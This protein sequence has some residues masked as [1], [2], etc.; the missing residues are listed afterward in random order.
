MNGN[1]GI[2]VKPIGRKLALIFAVMLI[3]STLAA[4]GIVIGLGYGMVSDL[5]DSSL[6]N[7][8]STDAGLVNRELNSTFYYLN[9]IGDTLE[10]CEFD[11]NDA[12][13]EYLAGTM[14][15]YPL[16]PTGSYL[17][18][19]DGTFLYPADPSFAYD[20]REQ[21]YFLEAMAYKNS[22]F[23][24]YDVPYFDDATGM[25]CA[26][27]QRKVTLKDGRVGV[28]IAD[29]MMDPIRETLEA[30][31]LYD[32]GKAMMVTKDG[33]ILCYS[34]ETM[35]GTYLSEH[36]DDEFLA[37]IPEVLGQED[38]IVHTIT[39]GDKYYVCTSNING[40]D[41][42]VIIYVKTSEVLA[43]VKQIVVALAAFTVIAVALVVLIISRILSKLIKKPVSELTRNIESIAGGD[44][45]V[46]VEAN[47]NDEIA[48]MNSAMGD[49]VGSMRNT[50]RDI[51]SVSEQ[52]RTEAR[53]SRETA[54]SLEGA[55]KEQSNSMEQVRQNIASI[56]AAVGEVASSATKLATTIEEVNKGEHQ[57]EESM[58]SLVEKAGIGQK[59][60]ISVSE[61]M[62][63]VV[64][65]M[66]E[67]ADAVVNVDEAA[68]KINNIVDMIDAISSQTNLLSLNASIEAA[69]AGEAGRGF[70][71]VASEIG[72]LANNSSQATSQI[73]AIILDMSAKVKLLSEKSEAN[74]E[75]I[76]NSA[77]YVNSAAATF[78]EITAELSDASKTLNTIA[79]QMT[80][81][82]DVALNMAAISEEQSASAE[83]ISNA[84]E[85]VT[86]AAKD[87]ATS[88][89]TV[90]NAAKSVADAV[91]D[92]NDNLEKF[93]I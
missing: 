65:S 36:E 10:Q 84:V 58:S 64:N 13:M 91:E 39:A 82:N 28:F 21:P 45:T 86:V 56:T 46:Q 14:G 7:E 63:D 87:V 50:I 40:T 24:Y 90:S 22:W 89:D 83:E 33:M 34:D 17:V 23:Y 6:S 77:G 74:S 30:V 53:T 47:G 59:D 42:Q 67:M 20:A 51:K 61:G 31:N 93:T 62:G 79:G 48:L 12:L 81:V 73:S 3:V 38:G 72:E 26:T 55:A 4:E 66:K 11:G 80:T 68:K 18:L 5:I 69:R 88:S 57:I 8:V 29:L 41:W 16:I 52:L 37:A 85:L 25:L 75:L 54:D 9:G 44:F 19:D 35:G 78:R 71:V 70:A 27:V 49:F 15:R 2:T 32:T 43:A 76:N 92:I 60:M 1:N